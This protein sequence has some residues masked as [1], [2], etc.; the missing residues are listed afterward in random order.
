MIELKG[1]IP[2]GNRAVLI[3]PVRPMPLAQPCLLRRRHSRFTPAARMHVPADS[4]SGQSPERKAATALRSL[5][6]F[7]AARVVLEQLQ[8]PAG[9]TLT[10]H[11]SYNQQAYL[12][13]MDFL[14]VPMKG[15]GG[16]E[17]LA[18][19]MRKNHALALR[20]MEVR[21][22]YLDEFEWQQVAEMASRETRE[23]NTR[24]MRAAAMASLQASLGG[25]VG[26]GSVHMSGDDLDGPSSAQS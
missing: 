2:T 5:F 19:V 13:L 20:L 21:E 15:D 7:V 26:N 6:T 9:P 18:K 16:D 22:A 24:L 25:A 17:W 3:R 8:G 11:T 1:S 23:A 4:F 12:D 14:G 10:G